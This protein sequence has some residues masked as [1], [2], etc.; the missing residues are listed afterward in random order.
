MVSGVSFPSPCFPTVSCVC[1]CLMWCLSGGPRL[2][3]GSISLGIVGFL[4]SGRMVRLVGSRW[5]NQCAT[6]STTCIGRALVSLSRHPNSPWLWPLRHRLWGLLV[7]RR[8]SFG[9]LLS[10]SAW[11]SENRRRDR[12]STVSEYLS[13]IFRRISG[14]HF[15]SHKHGACR[16]NLLLHLHF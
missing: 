5:R 1:T 7:L 16:A 8:P 11:P 15:I 3:D 6:C 9:R 13:D 10:P 2:A 14:S 12:I 4:I